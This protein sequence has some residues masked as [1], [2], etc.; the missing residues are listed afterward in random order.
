MKF[1]HE[2]ILWMQCFKLTRIWFGSQ[3]IQ[4]VE[5]SCTEMVHPVI[6]SWRPST[7][8]M[9]TLNSRASG[10][11]NLMK[12]NI[13]WLIGWLNDWLYIFKLIDLLLFVNLLVKC[14]YQLLLMFLSMSLKWSLGNQ[15]ADLKLRF[16]KGYKL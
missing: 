3:M 8:L 11:C 4:P 1:Q 15:Y 12:Y 2:V 13:H 16:L 9:G 6:P 14:I 7:C 10:L 5:Q